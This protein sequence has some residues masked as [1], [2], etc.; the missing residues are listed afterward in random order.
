MRSATESRV[1]PMFQ[2]LSPLLSWAVIWCRGDGAGHSQVSGP[3]P[4]ALFD[5]IREASQPYR[6]YLSRTAR[7]GPAAQSDLT[8]TLQSVNGHRRAAG[9]CKCT[10]YAVV[11]SERG[12][13]RNASVPQFNA[14]PIDT[15]ERAACTPKRR[16]HVWPKRLTFVYRGHRCKD[17]CYSWQKNKARFLLR[18]Q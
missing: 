9:S 4:F 5:P 2:S 10:V 12:D 13:G 15:A 17:S 18:T 14:L 16:Q 1:G 7:S 6:R 3:A 11:F 8:T